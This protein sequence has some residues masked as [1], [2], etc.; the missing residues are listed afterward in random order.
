MRPYRLQRRAPTLETKSARCQNRGFQSN[1]YKWSVKRARALQALQA[2]QALAVLSLF[3]STKTAQIQ[4][5]DIDCRVNVPQQMQ[6]IFSP[7]KL[8]EFAA[9]R[10]RAIPKRLPQ[11]LHQ[12][13]RQCF[14]FFAPILGHEHQIELN[15]KQIGQARCRS[16]SLLL[17]AVMCR[18]RRHSLRPPALPIRVCL[19]KLQSKRPCRPQCI[20][21][22]RQTRCSVFGVRLVLSG[23][24]LQKMGRKCG[25]L[26]NKVGEVIP[27]PVASVPSSLDET[28]VSRLGGNTQALGSLTPE[29][30]ATAQA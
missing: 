11:I 30:P 9:P 22:H 19:P 4:H 27:E 29:T 24:C 25:I 26:K 12:L 21:R 8:D 6:M 16:A 18:V 7:S 17:F 20:R 23:A 28:E 2:L 5:R 1:F 15:G 14:K 10:L 3:I 13:R